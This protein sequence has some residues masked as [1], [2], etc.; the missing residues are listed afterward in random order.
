VTTPPLWAKHN[1]RDNKFHGR[2]RH[3]PDHIKQALTMA[4][5][6]NGGLFSENAL[7]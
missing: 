4:P 2:H 5:Y 1:Y 7:D 3:F 6:L